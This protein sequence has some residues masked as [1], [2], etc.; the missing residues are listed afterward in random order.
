MSS[1]LG[2]Q[3]GMIFGLFFLMVFG[4]SDSG[5][6]GGGGNNNNDS[7][8]QSDNGTADSATSG[9][10]G[11]DDSDSSTPV[12]GTDGTDGDSGT[13][14][15]GGADSSGT[16]SEWAD[17]TSTDTQVPD[18]SMTDTSETDTNVT[19]TNVM[20]TSVTDTSVT[21]TNVT[22]TNVTDTSVTDTN[23]TDTNVTDTSETDTNVTDTSETDT[24]V[25]DTNVTDT[26][27]TDTNVTDTNVTDSGTV[28][29]DGDD[30]GV[31][32]TGS[33]DTG[34]VDPQSSDT[35]VSGTDSGDTSGTDTGTGTPTDTGVCFDG[36][37]QDGATVC[38][39][40]GRGVYVQECIGGSRVNTGTCTDTDNCADSDTQ[41]LTDACGY[42]S[43][44]EQL[45]IC[46]VG[47]WA[48]DVCTDPDDCVDSDTQSLPNS[49]GTNTR[50]SL[51]RTCATGAWVDGACTDTDECQD[52][53]TQSLVT[54]CGPNLRGSLGQLCV[55][56]VWED[57]TCADTDVCT[58]SDTQ[59]A[60]NNCGMNGRGDLLRRCDAGDWISD[61][62]V[63]TDPDVCQD[64]DTQV[65]TNAC[66][67]NTGGEQYQVCTTG[68][69]A[70]DYC[71][72]PDVC[73]DTNI[74]CGANGACAYDTDS[75]EYVYVCNCSA[76]YENADTADLTTACQDI[77]CYNTTSGAGCATN[78]RC[79]GTDVNA[80]CECQVGWAGTPA[81]A[82]G[83]DACDEGTLG[84]QSDGLGGCELIPS[85]IDGELVITEVMIEPT[86]STP[87]VN[88]QYFEI[89]NTSGERLN[90]A[91][92][93]IAIVG[94]TDSAV[95]DLPATPSV[96]VDADNYLV[97]GA[98]ADTDANG[99]VTVDEIL[100]GFPELGTDIGSISVS[101]NLGVVDAV[102]WDGASY[103]M[104]GGAS[105][106]LSPGVTLDATA[107]AEN[108]AA[109]LWCPASETWIAGDTDND[110]GSPGAMN[111]PCDVGNCG[112]IAPKV[113]VYKG[114]HYS[115]TDSDTVYAQSDT[116]NVQVYHPGVTEG[117]G[118]SGRA[119]AE[120]GY[121]ARYTDPETWE[122]W[123]SVAY[124]GDSGDTDTTVD[125]YDVFSGTFADIP[126]G[127]YFYAFRVSVDDGA[128]W[129]YCDVTWT[130]T[131]DGY[132]VMEGG[133][134]TVIDPSCVPGGAGECDD[135][136]DNDNNGLVDGM[137]IKCLYGLD[138]LETELRTGISSDENSV[139]GGPYDCFVDGNSGSGDDTC[140]QDSCC[141]LYDPALDDYFDANIADDDIG[142][143][144]CPAD[145]PAECGDGLCAEL[146]TNTTCPSD[147]AATCGDTTCDS[148]AGETA[149]TCPADCVASCGD[150]L[151]THTETFDTCSLDCDELCGNGACEL[152]HPACNL[153]DRSTCLV[154]SLG[155]YEPVTGCANMCVPFVPTGCDCWGCCTFCV[156]NVCANISAATPFSNYWNYDSSKAA[157]KSY[158]CNESTFD[159]P[160]K[161][162]RCEQATESARDCAIDCAAV[163]GDGYCTHSEQASNP[164]GGNYCASDCVATC[165]DGACNLDTDS[166][167]PANCPVD[168]TT[169]E[170]GDGVCAPGEEPVWSDTDS[171]YVGCDDCSPSCGDSD[172]GM[173]CGTRCDPE[174]CILC[175]GMTADDLPE[176]CKDAGGGHLPQ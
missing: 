16:D 133:V 168:C 67:M 63:C 170:C 137:D 150:G 131:Y 2:N 162:M 106:G 108:D 142:V 175:P 97:F 45:Q 141:Q 34:T 174:N 110:Y 51:A 94:D 32:D 84:Y 148:G 121:G 163:C 6:S 3:T 88:G 30:T 58:D 24:N 28:E 104:T 111:D 74:D 33:T 80:L 153:S 152:G 127:V 10:F 92:S 49:C 76:G 120:L 155:K 156:D 161:C 15:S 44:G 18:T 17:T 60:V 140:E 172:C 85:P 95:I 164:A 48:D 86:G 75:A 165:G 91:G 43:R 12:S 157:T 22:D 118:S 107:A 146:E 114:T 115:D 83:C 173:I 116:L 29:P 82:P 102:A 62:D 167:T 72:D 159:D 113:T 19:D 53:D 125:E 123:Q 119:V 145:C 129:T 41:T 77:P 46:T 122:T 135:C 39:V 169:P 55:T 126:I 56:G 37:L 124:S 36:L 98:S 154:G 99:G 23:V 70:D 40:N 112:I 78:A 105:M 132:D 100:P 27:V 149:A 9:I 13:G 1:K 130:D 109:N 54:S 35:G 171:E 138:T 68:A 151:C 96:L 20:D 42:N 144:N 136:E 147:C 128:S 81:S 7:A 73:S 31:I 25:T 101:G 64:S 57:G 65:L 176:H 8:T 11:T 134:M 21:D 158:A 47:G 38:G 139:P 71:D 5:G 4:C 61:T 66:G 52:S 160:S 117:V 50:G 87:V 26:N 79:D 69:W 90:L 166:E 103:A 89:Y 143:P 14:A 93:T 59:A